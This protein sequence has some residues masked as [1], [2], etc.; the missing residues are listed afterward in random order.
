MDGPFGKWAIGGDYS[1]H[2]LTET[3]VSSG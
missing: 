1:A 3:A 2:T